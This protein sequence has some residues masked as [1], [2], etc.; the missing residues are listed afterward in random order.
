[1]D[2]HGAITRKTRNLFAQS[3]NCLT[4]SVIAFS[5]FIN[6]HL[7]SEYFYFHKFQQHNLKIN[8]LASKD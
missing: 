2:L 7:R 3:P 1:M 6:A 8:H 4:Y 5:L